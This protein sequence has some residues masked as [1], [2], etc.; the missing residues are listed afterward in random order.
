ML[1]LLQT[2]CP[3][4]TLRSSMLPCTQ[5]TTHAW[6]LKQLKGGIFNNSQYKWFVQIEH[7]EHTLN[8][9]V[10][11]K[12]TLIE[13]KVNIRNEGGG[14]VPF[15]P[16]ERFQNNSYFIILVHTFPVP[17]QWSGIHLMYRNSFCWKAYRVTL[18]TSIYLLVIKYTIKDSSE[19][20]SIWNKLLTCS[21]SW[22]L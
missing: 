12:Q 2:I 7:D 3:S 21:V 4:R 5:E 13:L 18:C 22:Y 8:F 1:T 14:V 15:K 16:G 10:F 11:N 20:I 19:N 17:S 9:P 6:H